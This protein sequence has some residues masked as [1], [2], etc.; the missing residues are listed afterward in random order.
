MVNKKEELKKITAKEFLQ[1]KTLTGLEVVNDI[2]LSFICDQNLY[3]IEAD[4]SNIIFGTPVEVVTDF[5]L[6]GD[7]LEFKTVSLN[8]NNIY[9]YR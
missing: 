3:G 4:T 2:L 9:L 8:L 1:G 7:V 6:N 5:I